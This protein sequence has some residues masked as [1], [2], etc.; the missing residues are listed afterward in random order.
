MNTHHFFFLILA[1]DFCGAVVLR[2]EGF[3]TRRLGPTGNLAMAL[4]ILINNE[5]GI[6]EDV[7]A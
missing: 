1:D 3:D 5:L 4:P 6:I 2:S 7:A